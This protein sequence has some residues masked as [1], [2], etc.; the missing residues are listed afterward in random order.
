MKGEKQ[1]DRETKKPLLI[2]LAMIML[3]TSIPL[4]TFATEDGNGTGADV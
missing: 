4:S 1:D 2:L 3:L